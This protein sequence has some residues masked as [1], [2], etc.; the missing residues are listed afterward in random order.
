MA[1]YPLA[2]KPITAYSQDPRGFAFWQEPEGW[3]GQEALY[4]T[5]ES[6]HPDREALVAEFQPYFGELEAIAAIPLTRGG[7]ETDTVLVYRTTSQQRAY[8]YPYP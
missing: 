8:D 5:L 6:L 4:L 1:L 7:A 3:V 2:Q